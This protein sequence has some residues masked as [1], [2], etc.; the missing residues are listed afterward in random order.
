MGDMY[1]SLAQTQPNQGKLTIYF[2]HGMAWH[3]MAWYGMVWY[4]MVWHGNA[5]HCI[6]ALMYYN[7]LQNSESNINALLLNEYD[8]M[9]AQQHIYLQQMPK[10][11]SIILVKMN[12]EL[13]SSVQTLLILNGNGKLDT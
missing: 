9:H 5:R 13:K 3:G 6:H 8:E 7:M 12:A 4:G 1:F 10:R 2:Y 11:D